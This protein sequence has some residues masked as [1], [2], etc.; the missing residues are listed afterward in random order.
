MLENHPHIFPDFPDIHP[1]VGDAGILDVDFSFGGLLQ[2]IDASKKGGFSGTGGA[3][4][5]HHLAF[6]YFHGHI[7]QHFQASEILFQMF[8][9]NHLPAPSFPDISERCKK[10]YHT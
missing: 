3:K 10:H 6:F 1:P 5:R 8:D 2:Q 7:L 4:D 9:S